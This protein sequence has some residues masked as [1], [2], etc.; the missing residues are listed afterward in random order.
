MTEPTSEELA[1]AAKIVEA[2]NKFSQDACDA[3]NAS[4]VEPAPGM[5][6]ALMYV[7][8]PKE[9]EGGDTCGPVGGSL[10]YDASAP[11]GAPWNIYDQIGT[12]EKQ[13]AVP[14]RAQSISSSETVT[15]GEGDA[16]FVFRDGGADNPEGF[17]VEVVP[18]P[19]LR[20]SDREREASAV[21]LQI[22]SLVTLYF[23]EGGDEIRRKLEA[24]TMS[25]IV[26][27]AKRKL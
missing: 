22:A 21:T 25:K 16:A 5:I 3:L 20:D 14:V 18:G 27:D 6:C 24:V 15:L 1:L 7:V 10:N 23:H 26:E 12:F 13:A 17:D 19:A 9:E 4:G 8:H 11:D 2:K